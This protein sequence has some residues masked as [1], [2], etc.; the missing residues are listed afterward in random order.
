MLKFR[1]MTGVQSLAMIGVLLL[2]ACGG[3]GA[4]DL[5]PTVNPDEIRTQAV[6]TFSAALT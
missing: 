5:T 6:G 1:L 3:A 2:S 4:N